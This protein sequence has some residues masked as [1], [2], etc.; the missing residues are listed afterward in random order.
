[1]EG[2]D[3]F[4]IY[5]IQNKINNKIYVGQ[6][7]NPKIRWN[8]H[9]YEGIINKKYY[10][11]LSMNKHGID[12]FIYTIIEDNLSLDDAN[13]WEVFYIEFFQSQNKKFGYNNTPGGKNTLMSVETRKKLSEANKGENNPN[14]GK[15]TSEETKKKISEA[16]TGTVRPEDFKKKI[17]LFHKGKQY[18][19]GHKNSDTHNTKISQSHI[20][21]KQ[22]DEH[23]KKNSESHK[24]KPS[25]NKSKKLNLTAEQRQKIS[26]NSKNRIVSMETRQKL[27]ALQAGENHSC[28]KL[29]WELVGKIRQEYASDNISQK[30]LGK[31]YGVH[32]GHITKIVTNKAWKYK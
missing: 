20:G 21:K 28:A 32:Q 4:V 9:K 22:T 19:L 23:K 11:Y 16:I 8:R 6:T 18:R 3:K 27:S 26:D 12:N 2:E 15:V 10:L 1:M 25:P 24:G 5:V 17:S 14:Y 29:T 30:E 7:K 31:K 13:Y